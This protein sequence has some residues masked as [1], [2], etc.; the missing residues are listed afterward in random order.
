MVP[1]TRYYREYYIF[2]ISY[3]FANY[4]HSVHFCIYK[5]PINAGKS[6]VGL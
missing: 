3:I 5:Y 6:A 2:D 4:L 1:L